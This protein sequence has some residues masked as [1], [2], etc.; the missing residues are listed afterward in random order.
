MESELAKERADALR[1]RP[2]DSTPVSVHDGDCATRPP[3][4]PARG[5]EHEA[6]AYG[7]VEARQEVRSSQVASP[8]P[9]IGRTLSP[10]SLMQ[11]WC[12]LLPA[13]VFLVVLLLG[14]LGFAAAATVS[15]VILAKRWR[16][17]VRFRWLHLGLTIV[18]GALAIA[19][20]ALPIR[21][22]V[23]IGGGILS[24]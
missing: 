19:L 24:A 12:V 4:A 18:C 10:A 15:S 7:I 16:S 21:W 3:H 11:N 9:R 8:G 2:A 6:E 1:K 17:G 23:W 14:G 13:A 5:A 22:L 20:L